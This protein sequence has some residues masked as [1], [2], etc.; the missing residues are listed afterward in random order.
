M[1]PYLHCREVVIN[2]QGQPHGRYH[3]ELCPERVVVRVVRCLEL[4]E[5]KV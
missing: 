1:S 2:E 5:H 3:E 4:E